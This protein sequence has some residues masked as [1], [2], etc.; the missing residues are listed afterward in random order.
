MNPIIVVLQALKGRFLTK[1]VRPRL[2][3][4]LDEI[5]KRCAALPELDNR[6]PDAIIGYDEFGLPR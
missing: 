1:K 2:A 5:A 3:D 6:T 4:E